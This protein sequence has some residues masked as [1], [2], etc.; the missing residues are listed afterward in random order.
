MTRI[1]VLHP[2]RT[3][4][5]RRR[6]EGDPGSESQTTMR[7][8]NYLF[9]AQRAMM[10]APGVNEQV[11]WIWVLSILN[12]SDFDDANDI[13]VEKLRLL[14]LLNTTEISDGKEPIRLS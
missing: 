6:F 10:D 12:S 14:G 4:E 13:V 3:R 2:I 5:H 7:C 11:L 9:D 8:R 1:P